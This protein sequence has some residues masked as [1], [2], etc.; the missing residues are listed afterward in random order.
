MK[1][2]PQMKE[3]VANMQPGVITLHGFLGTDSRTLQ[4]MLDED[5]GT[6]TRLGLSHE[7]L[8]VKM[9]YFREEGKR[10]LGEIISVSPHFEVQVQSVRGI[11]P[12]PFG[13][14][15]TIPKQNVTV[16]NKKLDREI[17]FTELNIHMVEK[18]GF[19]EGKGSPFRVSP[20]DLIEILEIK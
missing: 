11:L 3:I 10:G 6:V 16:R 18:H 2:T 14:P 9:K 20:R 1:E 15:G 8:A 19:Y 4:D 17:T 12:C 7:D 13:H 5:N